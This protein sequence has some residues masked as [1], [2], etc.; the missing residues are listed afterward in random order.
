MW[1]KYISK[2]SG[3]LNLLLVTPK[4]KK[5]CEKAADYEYLLLQCVPDCYMTQEKSEEADG[6]YHFTLMFVLLLYAST[7]LHQ[8]QTMC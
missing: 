4:L 2:S 7:L 8:T 1:K 5:M 6:T 3:I